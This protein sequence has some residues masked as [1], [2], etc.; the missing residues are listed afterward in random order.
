[1]ARLIDAD[2]LVDAI[3]YRIDEEKEIYP[4]DEF[5]RFSRVGMRTV[6]G[7]IKNQDTVDPVK[8]GHWILDENEK[9]HWWNSVDNVNRNGMLRYVFKPVFGAEVYLSGC[10]SDFRGVDLENCDLRESIL[11]NYNFSNAF[12]RSS[13]LSYSMLNQV[14]FCSIDLHVAYQIQLFCIQNHLIVFLC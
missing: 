9:I 3:K 10:S 7:I 6:I 11:I 5:S 14:I 4:D 13:N 2:A 1:M 8:H 12:L